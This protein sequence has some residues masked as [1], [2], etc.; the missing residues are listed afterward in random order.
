MDDRYQGV[1][2]IDGK[3]LSVLTGWAKGPLPNKRHL[4]VMATQ[5]NDDPVGTKPW[6]QMLAVTYADGSVVGALK[7][8]HLEML[9]IC[10][11]HPAQTTPAQWQ[12]HFADWFRDIKDLIARTLS[13]AASVDVVAVVPPSMTW[14]PMQDFHAYMIDSLRHD[15]LIINS[16]PPV[17]GFI[18]Y[19]LRIQAP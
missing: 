2:H 7:G 12:P 19:T 5:Y 4:C 10:R 6:R 9:G 15:N 3:G 8:I 16:S 1:T 17:D 18:T 14:A 11:D 13:G